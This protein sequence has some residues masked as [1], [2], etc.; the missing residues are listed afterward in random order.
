MGN[1]QDWLDGSDVLRMSLEI[2]GTLFTRRLFAINDGIPNGDQWTRIQ[3][4]DIT[5]HPDLGTNTIYISGI[6]HTIVLQQSGKTNLLVAPD[7]G[8]LITGPNTIPYWGAPGSEIVLLNFHDATA[9][10]A[11]SSTIFQGVGNPSGPQQ[12]FQVNLFD[13]NRNNVPEMSLFDGKDGLARSQLWFGTRYAIQ[14]TNNL[15]VVDINPEA[16]DGSTP[17]SLSTHT[18][19]S[20]GKLFTVSNVGTNFVGIPVDQA[21]TN[22]P[23]ILNING[24]QKRVHVGAIDSGGTGLRALTIEN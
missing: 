17:F 11:D 9:G 4:G 1:I 8:G 13:T 18:A 3:Y 14:V 21:A 23:L 16:I 2:D 22:A 15:S 5:I 20:S 12:T 6:D 19:H 7:S 10:D 24:T